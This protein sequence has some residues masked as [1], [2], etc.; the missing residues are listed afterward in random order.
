MALTI[1]RGI[2]IGGDI[3]IPGRIYTI[4]TNNKH[5]QRQRLV[6]TTENKL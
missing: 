3:H 5:K 2:T 1:G 6:L 4:R